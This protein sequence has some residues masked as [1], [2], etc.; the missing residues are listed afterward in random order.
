MRLV[1]F[2]S[3]LLSVSCGGG[4]DVIQPAATTPRANPSAPVADKASIAAAEQKA[5]ADAKPV[6]DK[7]CARCHTS[8]GEKADKDTLKHL[9]MDTYPFGG[10][11]AMEI[12]DEIREVL[13]MTGEDPTMP[14]DAPGAVKG[15][16]LD[17]II[18]W[19]NAFDAAHAAGVH[20]HHG[21]HGAH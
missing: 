14:S 10:H 16:E 1:V 2:A 11:H 15:D 8:S 12:G 6:F 4:K 19:S 21:D 7:H 9:N 5:F 3:V 18:I 20:Q 17:L 13:G